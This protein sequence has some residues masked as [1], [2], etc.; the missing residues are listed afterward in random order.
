MET[1]QK[2]AEAKIALED[3]IVSLE[4]AIDRGSAAVIRKPAQDIY[5]ENPELF[6]LHAAI[7]RTAMMAAK[8]KAEL[9]QLI[10]MEPFSRLT[11]L[12]PRVE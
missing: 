7:A 9:L 1:S 4:K 3:M 8:A 2:T 11:P 10:G 12:P 5:A 6:E